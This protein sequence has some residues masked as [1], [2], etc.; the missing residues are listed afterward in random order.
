MAN[1]DEK[2]FLWLN[3]L[4][5]KSPVFDRIVEWVVSDYLMPVVLSLALILLWFIGEDRGT[6]LKH[7]VGVFAALSSMALA[8][9][10]VFVI[11]AMYF[12]PRPFVD[13]DVTLLF[14][15]PTDSSFPANAMA[16][17]FGLAIGVWCVNRRLG[18]LMVLAA[19]LFA[20][21]RVVAGVHY[22]AD[23]AVGALI[24]A[25]TAYLVS[26]GKSLL[27][28]VPTWVVKAARILCLA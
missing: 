13:L 3:G 23:V 14:Y 11:N 1:A 4:A 7:Q 2:L 6:R 5:G 19:G 16:A 28:P 22:P 9:L 8:S 12:R 17:S 10:V 20:F 21:A 15:Q 24:G 26:K 25:V 18:A 27:G